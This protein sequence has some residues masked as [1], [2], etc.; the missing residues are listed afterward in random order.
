MMLISHIVKT[1]EYFIVMGFPEITSETFLVSIQG[2][3]YD[4]AKLASI[5]IAMF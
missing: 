1:I 5:Y 2:L 4:I 3:I